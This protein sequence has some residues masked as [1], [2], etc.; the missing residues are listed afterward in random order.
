MSN[1]T[2]RQRVLAALNHLPTDLVPFDLGG[3]KTTSLNV[4]AQQNLLNYL[5]IE[6]PTVW[7]DYRSQRTHIPEELAC[8]LDTD[9]R[10]VQIPH[11]LPLPMESTQPVQIDPWGIEWTQD[12]TGLFHVSRPPLAS[13]EGPSEL[14]DYPWPSP[15]SLQPVEDLA[16]AA[17]KLRSETDCAICLDLPDLVVHTSQNMRGYQAWLLDTAVNVR[18]LENLMDTIADIYV[19]MVT[20]LLAT[21]GESID[22]VMVCDD[23]A[24]QRGPLI[25]PE[26]Y[27]RLIKPRQAR[28]LAAIRSSTQA[29]IVFHTCGSVYW[30][31]GDLVDLGI[32]GLNPVQTAAAEMDPVRLKREAGNEICFW[33][34]IDTQHILP[35]GSPDEVRSEVRRMI[36]ALAADG[37]GYVLGPVHIIQAEVPPQNILAMAEAAHAYGGRPDGQRFAV[38]GPGHDESRQGGEHAWPK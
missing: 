14:R 30:A 20:R 8:F 32:D 31:L 34:G 23:I 16:A 25:R 2:P 27:R 9:V 19:A 33:G 15:E 17:W 26:S 38:R 29:R 35:F 24:I 3:T 7:G 5:G 12:P 1:L 21:V 6:A 10:R 13:I 28:I 36:D 22:L 11:P 37:T 4:H 18:L